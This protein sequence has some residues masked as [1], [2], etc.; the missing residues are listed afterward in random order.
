MDADSF[1]LYGA[2]LYARKEMKLKDEEIVSFVKEKKS[3]YSEDRIRAGIGKMKKF[4]KDARLQ[5]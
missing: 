2:I 5:K 1:E 3:W 4:L